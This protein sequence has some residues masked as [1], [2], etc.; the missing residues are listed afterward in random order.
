MNA[1]QRPTIVNPISLRSADELRAELSRVN[2]ELL[3]HSTQLS[4][5]YGKYQLLTLF[6]NHVYRQ[7][8]RGDFRGVA[9]LLQHQLNALPELRE[10]FEEMND[11]S[12]F[13]H[14][15]HWEKSARAKTSGEPMPEYKSGFE[16]PWQL[17]DVAVLQLKLDDA[18]RA[19]I[20]QALRSERLE[21]SLKSL[22][23]GV[24]P[25][26]TAHLE[27]DQ[28][29]VLEAVANFVETYVRSSPRH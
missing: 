19:G 2:G 7:H 23:N 17:G 27:G 12:D 24:W 6:A 14:I 26:V 16:D 8:L 11:F 29:G 22:G 1:Q 5:V 18:H 10:A 21:A 3:A 4:T 25:F 28:A 13:C 15:E 9:A 20:E